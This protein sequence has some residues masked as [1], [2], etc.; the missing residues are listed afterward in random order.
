MGLG[1]K[2]IEFF[3]RVL[4]NLA[5]RVGGSNWPVGTATVSTS[6]L[7]RSFWGCIVVAVHYKYRN[8]DKRFEGIHEQPFI[9]DNYAEAYLRR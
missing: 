4:W 5:R 1:I 2:Y 3:I 6:E 8:A 9:F 7:R